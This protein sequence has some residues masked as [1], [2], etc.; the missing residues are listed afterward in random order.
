[1]SRRKLSPSE[2]L[3]RLQEID[4]LTSDG[5]PLGEAIRLA[6]VLPDEYGRW[7]SE[8]AGLLRTLGPLLEAGPELVRK[9]VYARALRRSR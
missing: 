2:I 9:P 3:G 5:R 8:Y 6:G 1:M 4:A 7:L